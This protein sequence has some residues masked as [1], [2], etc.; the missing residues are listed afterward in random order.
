MS[1]SWKLW[2]WCGGSTGACHLFV[3]TKAM[4]GLIFKRDFT[5]STHFLTH[6]PPSVIRTRCFLFL[7]LDSGC[8][9][10][11]LCNA[12]VPT[13]S[14]SCMS[15]ALAELLCNTHPEGGVASGEA[16]KRECAYTLGWR[17]WRSLSQWGRQA[18]HIPEQPV[19]PKGSEWGQ[20]VNFTQC[21]SC[22]SHCLNRFA[23]L[24]RSVLTDG[25]HAISKVIILSTLKI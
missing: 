3:V 24:T 13:L 23:N 4:T 20:Q 9:A 14:W 5:E 19:T 18:N 1:L 2:S 22:S 25:P 8:V 10:M 21:R 6:S 15:T 11:G 17:P 7:E 12:C 16:P